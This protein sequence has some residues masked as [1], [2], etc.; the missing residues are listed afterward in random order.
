MDLGL[1]R[2]EADEGI[3]LGK[4]LVKRLGLGFW[5]GRRLLCPPPLGC[6]ELVAA[7]GVAA[8]RQAQGANVG[9][10]RARSGANRRDRPSV[11]R[12]SELRSSELWLRARSMAATSGRV[13]AGVGGGVRAAELR[14]RSDS[15]VAG[16]PW[17][18]CAE[19]LRRATNLGHRFGVAAGLRAID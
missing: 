10:Q 16:G 13:V 14:R 6:A 7:P 4:Q 15:R 3:E 19:G 9:P 18:R 17:V 5:L 2:G 8:L 11:D 1:D 12:S